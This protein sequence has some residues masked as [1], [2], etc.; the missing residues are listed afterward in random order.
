MNEFAK[1]EY[2]RI[3]N[4]YHKDWDIGRASAEKYPPIFRPGDRR[5]DALEAY[6][7]GF[8]YGEEGMLE[9]C[10]MGC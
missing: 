4:P 7:A 10:K 5:D 8:K 3:G 6:R 1:T 9:Y 2:Q